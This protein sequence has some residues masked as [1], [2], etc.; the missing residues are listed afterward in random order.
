MFEP[1]SGF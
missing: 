1:I